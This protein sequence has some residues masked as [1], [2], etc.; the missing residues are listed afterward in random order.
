MEHYRRD[1]SISHKLENPFADV[2]KNENICKVQISEYSQL[3]KV[4]GYA[5]SK[6]RHPS[7]K[8]ILIQG[9]GKALHKVG[10]CVRILMTKHD[11]LHRCDALTHKIHED[12]WLPIDTESNLDGISVK[13]HIPAL[14]VILAK[15]DLPVALKTHPQRL[16]LKSASNIASRPETKL[17]SGHR[18]RKPHK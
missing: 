2:L 9:Q 12:I 6:L 11:N 10:N 7:T 15:D 5:I 8:L 17:A 13:R 14:F 1:K 18:Q 3:S 4:L 16:Q